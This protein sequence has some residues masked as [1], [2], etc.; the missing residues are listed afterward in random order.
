MLCR[1]FWSPY[2]NKGTEAA[3][4]AVLI[5]FHQCSCTHSTASVQLHQVNIINVIFF[6]LPVRVKQQIPAD[7]S[8]P[9]GEMSPTCSIFKISNNLHIYYV[10]SQ[11]HTDLTVFSPFS[12]GFDVVWFSCQTRRRKYG[13]SLLSQHIF[14]LLRLLYCIRHYVSLLGK[15]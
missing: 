2:P 7:F 8:T 10:H 1:K 6:V 9:A 14:H 11:K 3:R 12:E 13:A 5:Q 15:S 4:T